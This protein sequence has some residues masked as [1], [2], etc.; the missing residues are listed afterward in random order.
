MRVPVRP[1]QEFEEVKKIRCLLKVNIKSVRVKINRVSSVIRE[2]GR[3]NR[4]LKL[5]TELKRGLA[6]ESG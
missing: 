4:Y 6:T 3:A 5:F 2:T 1:S